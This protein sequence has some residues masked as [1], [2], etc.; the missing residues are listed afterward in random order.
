M[1]KASQTER[2]L[3]LVCVLLTSEIGM[4]KSE[5]YQAVRGYQQKADGNSEAL[6]K[7]FDRDKDLICEYGVQLVSNGNEKKH[8]VRYRIAEG[9]FSW[10][11]DL[12]LSGRQLELLELAAMAW[13]KTSIKNFAD[14]GLIKLRALGHNIDNSIIG[15]AP[16]ITIS[17]QNF[18]ILSSAILEKTA[19]K[20]E[21]LKLDAIKSEQKTVLPLKIRNI[22]GEW[23]LLAKD[24][25]NSQ[26][27][28]YLL[29]RIS[30]SVS[31]SNEEIQI[32]S[33]EIERAETDLEQYIQQN[34]AELWIREDSEAEFK[35]GRSGE[36][37][38][39]YMDEELLSEDILDLAADVRVI[40][41]ESLA[42]RVTDAIQ[43]V[44]SEHA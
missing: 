4:T 11:K 23:V 32:R 30:S 27:K 3:N 7:L 9:E 14:F 29:R 38:I 6:D 42:K 8:N 41:P 43:R 40:S 19:V 24:A 39:N 12:E 35:Y 13:S 44:V 2:L 26:V 34:V 28:N 20:F 31:S 18:E 33:V 25:K 37:T 15:L 5:L 10:P 1:E 22:E 17:D 16:R 36:I 21:Y